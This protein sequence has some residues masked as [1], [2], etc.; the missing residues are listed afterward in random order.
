MAARRRPAD[1]HLNLGRPLRARRR[2]RR[3][4]PGLAADLL[5]VDAD[6]RQRPE[7]LSEPT[8]VLVRGVR[9]TTQNTG[10]EVEP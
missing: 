8:R 10:P 6:L 7:K 2:D 4:R 1:R 3:L 5:V 9:A